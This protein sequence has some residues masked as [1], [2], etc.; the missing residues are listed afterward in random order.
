[1]SYARVPSSFKPLFDLPAK[2]YTNKV[3]AFI[4]NLNLTFSFCTAALTMTRS[5][6]LMHNGRTPFMSKF[7]E[8]F[9]DL[10]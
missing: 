4:T 10:S 3:T 8:K 9:S 1:M 6:A 7:H 5:L 2:E